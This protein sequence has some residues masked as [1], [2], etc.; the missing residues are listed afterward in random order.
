MAR[1]PALGFLKRERKRRTE[2]R[3]AK[4]KKP[5]EGGLCVSRSRHRSR[6]SLRFPQCVSLLDGSDR[7]TS[8]AK[9]VEAISSTLS[10][11]PILGP[12]LFGE[13]ASR[14]NRIQNYCEQDYPTSCRHDREDQAASPRHRAFR[15]NTIWRGRCPVTQQRPLIARYSW[16]PMMRRRPNRATATTLGVRTAAATKLAR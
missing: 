1:L 8:R 3:A 14:K 4:R 12:D 11:L 2:G 15:P 9:G 7:R 10:A 6:A 13:G 16:P 5:P